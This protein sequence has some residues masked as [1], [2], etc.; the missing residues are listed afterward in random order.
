MM[1][2]PRTAARGNLVGALG[3]L[4]AIGA[5][6]QGGELDLGLLLVALVVGSALGVVIALKVKMTAMPEM[7][8]LL[9]GLGGAASVLVA[10]GEGAPGGAAAVATKKG[11]W[12]LIGGFLAAAWKFVAA[13][14]VA[15]LAG[16]GKMFKKKT[17]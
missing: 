3:M 13:A 17:E 1:G 14:V 2:H 16:I 11:F 7:V 6:L 8:G 15:L 4:V 10:G 12:A 9:N 5:T